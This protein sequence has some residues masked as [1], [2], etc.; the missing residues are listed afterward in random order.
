MDSFPDITAKPLFMSSNLIAA[1]K[2]ID[3]C[4]IEP[5]SYFHILR[6]FHESASSS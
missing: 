6:P 4:G 3:S 5:R 1:S 2:K